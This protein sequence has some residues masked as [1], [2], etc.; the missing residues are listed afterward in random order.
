M[1]RPTWR[2][3]DVDTEHCDKAGVGDSAIEEGIGLL[4]DD[5][6]FR[7]AHAHLL[8]HRMRDMWTG[9]PLMHQLVRDAIAETPRTG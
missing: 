9:L 1:L 6:N 3:Y 8:L 2:C 7:L 5:L 4:P